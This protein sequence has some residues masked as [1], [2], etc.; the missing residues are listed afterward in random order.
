MLSLA[1]GAAL[2]PMKTEVL[3]LLAAL[4]TLI[5]LGIYFWLA[6]KEPSEKVRGLR[7]L[8]LLPLLVGGGVGIGTYQHVGDF[9]YR[10]FHQLSEVYVGLCRMTLILPVVGVIAILAMEIFSL[11]RKRWNF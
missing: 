3:A 11:K 2:A 9:L 1:L 7:W 10:E 5:G 4:P 6:R 8:G